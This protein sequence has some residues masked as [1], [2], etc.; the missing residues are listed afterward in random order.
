MER[1][2]IRSAIYSF[3]KAAEMHGDFDQKQI[4]SIIAQAEKSR[5]MQNIP[6]YEFVITA[7]QPIQKHK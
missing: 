6:I 7:N 2:T 4:V 1:L 3:M 5:L